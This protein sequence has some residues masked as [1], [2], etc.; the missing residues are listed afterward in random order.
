LT[1]GREEDKKTE[2]SVFTYMQKNL[3]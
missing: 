1:I 2:H 3:R